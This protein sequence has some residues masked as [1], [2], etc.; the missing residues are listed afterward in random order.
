MCHNQDPL[1]DDSKMTQY[2]L[3]IQQISSLTK[4]NLL[5]K[6]LYEK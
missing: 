6:H 1:F 4:D 2:Y 3:G 5:T